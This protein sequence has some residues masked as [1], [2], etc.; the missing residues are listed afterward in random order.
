MRYTCNIAFVSTK[1]MM[2]KKK[3]DAALRK[4]IWTISIV[5]CLVLLTWL[6]DYIPRKAYGWLYSANG[7]VAYMLRKP[8]VKLYLEKSPPH[9]YFIK[10]IETLGTMNLLVPSADVLRGS[11]FIIA[12][13]FI[14]MYVLWNFVTLNS[15]NAIISVLA[16]A[17]LLTFIAAIVVPQ[18]SLGK[19]VTS[20]FFIGQGSN[21]SRWVFF[22]VCSV[23][24]IVLAAALTWVLTDN[25]DDHMSKTTTRQYAMNTYLSCSLISGVSIALAFYICTLI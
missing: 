25:R 18:I 3:S 7:L 19:E 16:G 9:F 8:L 12:F 23:L 2:E 5:A 13:T 22:K 6:I 11:A 15:P 17:S 21:G 24:G 10:C 4:A 20:L 14:P 1:S